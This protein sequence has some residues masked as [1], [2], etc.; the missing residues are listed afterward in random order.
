MFSTRDIRCYPHQDVSVPNPKSETYLR[1]YLKLILFCFQFSF[2]GSILVLTYFTYTFYHLSRKPISIV[3]NVLNRNCSELTPPEWVII[4]DDNKDNWCDWAP[5]GKYFLWKPTM[6]L[7][8]VFLEK[9]SRSHN[10]CMIWTCDY[11]LKNFVFL[12][13]ILM[14]PSWKN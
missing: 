1:T 9:L 4:T 2:Q 13:I 11:S 7:S 5:F 3:K 8:C 14:T 6:L 12:L 10:E